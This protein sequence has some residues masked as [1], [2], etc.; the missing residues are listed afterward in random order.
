MLKG[1]KEGRNMLKEGR[2]EGGY[3]IG[4]GGDLEF[5]HGSRSYMMGG[6]EGK[7]GRKEKKERKERMKDGRTDG[8][9]GRKVTKEGK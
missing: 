9:E 4:M 6:R 1:R 2:K 3:R 5:V 7:D 8:K